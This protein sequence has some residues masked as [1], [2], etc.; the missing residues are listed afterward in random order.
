MYDPTILAR[1]YAARAEGFHSLAQ[2]GSAMTRAIYLRL[3]GMFEELAHAAERFI[4]APSAVAPQAE[5]PAQSAAEPEPPALPPPAKAK[6]KR[7]SKRPPAT[8][9]RFPETPAAEEIRH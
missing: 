8:P 5:I 2:E 1:H 7:G 4:A 6:R 9:P 3:A